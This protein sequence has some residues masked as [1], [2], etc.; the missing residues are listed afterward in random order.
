M[1]DAVRGRCALLTLK[2]MKCDRRANPSIPG[3]M[4]VGSLSESGEMLIVR[5]CNGCQHRKPLLRCQLSVF[6]QFYF[7]GVD[8]R[9]VPGR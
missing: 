7:K 8:T 1:Q 9:L 4:I 6:F 3:I 5:Y 2:T